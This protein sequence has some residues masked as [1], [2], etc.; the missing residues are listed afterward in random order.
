M[1]AVTLVS[2]PLHDGWTLT[3]V[4]GEAP[5]EVAATTVPTQVPG[6]THTDLARAGLIPDP[7]VGTHESALEWM[8]GCTWRYTANFA[9]TPV[10]QG[11]RIDLVF[12]GLDTVA[13]IRLND[14]EVA[15]T[16]NMHR[17][18][19]FDVRALLDAGPNTLDIEFEP[20]VEYAADV[21]SQL[22]ARPRAYAHPFNAVRK[23]ACSFGWDWG[24]ALQTAG[25][26]KDVRLERWRVA[27]LESVRPLVSVADGVGTVAVHVEV[28]R[29]R[30]VDLTVFA[31]I[32]GQE[33]TGII[34]ASEDQTVVEV[35]VADPELWWPAGYGQPHLY[36]L[37]VDLHSA[38]EHLDHYAT[39]VGFRTVQ[40]DTTMDDAGAGFTFIVNGVRIFVKGAN[41]V[42]DDHLLT[43]T[44][45][46]RLRRRLTQAL[47]AHINLVRV[48]GGGIYESDDFY[49]LCDEMGLLVW[50]DFPFACAAYAEDSPLLEEV[51][52]EARDNITRLSPHASL[53]MY[54]GSNE[55]IWGYCDW[56]WK[57]ELGDM[58]WG[59]GYYTQVLPGILAELDPTRFYTPSSP[60]SPH[61]DHTDKHPNDPAW[62]TFHEWEVWNRA[63]YSQYRDTVPRLCA[64]FGFQGPATWATISRSLPVEELH[65]DHP[66]WLAHQKAADG[67]G[68]LNRGLEPH[69]PTPQDSFEQWH[70]ATQLNQARAVQYGI[71]HYRSHWPHC[72]GAIVWQLNDCWPVTSWAAIDSDE[73]KKPLWYG[74]KAAYAPR[75][76]TFQPRGDDGGNDPHGTVRLVAVNDTAHAW[77]ETLTFTRMALDGTEQAVGT[78]H[79]SVPPR[80]AVTVEVP[81]HVRQAADAGGEVLIADA[82]Y[83]GDEDHVRALWAFA[84][85][86]D[87]AYSPAPFTATATAVEGGYQV[88]VT[89]TGLV[90]DLTI[91]ADKVAADAQVDA[92]LV[93]MVA[94][95]T[96]VFRITTSQ[97]VD[98]DAF[99]APLVLVSVNS[100]VAS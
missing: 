51:V 71:E 80:Q 9:A 68:K 78:A 91:L 90:R 85:D 49:D 44:S 21:E 59:L 5:A 3:H 93:T 23:M 13:T 86:K 2:K 8:W 97:D 31:T 89:A 47:D 92:A 36:D 33:V 28:E 55:N 75:L 57:D 61:H 82:G 69:L 87:I 70:W 4:G 99:L 19:R 6:T 24:P 50:Q 72:A 63:D 43:R 46:D 12:D 76:L 100:L 15:R 67:N 32:A 81:A 73:R 29:A 18:Y 65:Q 11:G 54:N 7:Y 77:D 45:K 27:R 22:G 17:Q 10:T 37:A 39:R 94:D 56:G 35:K 1:N 52:A 60:Y 48:G 83:A 74:L 26:W 79:L 30:N 53:V 98:P 38:D 96:H 84:E 62:G 58:S 88:T 40:V 66:A 16:K 41:W 95:D 14:S 42:P 20:A 64:E 25:I 34:P